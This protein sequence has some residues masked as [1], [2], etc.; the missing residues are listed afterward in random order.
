MKSVYKC[1]I[2]FTYDNPYSNE[3]ILKLYWMTIKR[4]KLWR[5]CVLNYKQIHISLNV[6]SS[7]I[8]FCESIFN[9][10]IYH[11]WIYSRGAT[12]GDSFHQMHTD[13]YWMTC[14]LP[15]HL[16][17]GGYVTA[18]SRCHIATIFEVHGNMTSHPVSVVMHLVERIF[19]GSSPTNN[20]DNESTRSVCK[21]HSTLISYVLYESY[22]QCLCY[23]YEE[24]KIPI[25]GYFNNI[26]LY[27]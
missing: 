20:N 5:K 25:I 8:I 11:L 16:H 24:N 9:F 15:V 4:L 18:R 2:F 21:F 27:F 7:S 26:I 3:S 12:V 13:I 19:Y 10:N 14:H 1:N 23:T 22:F 6:F 17:N